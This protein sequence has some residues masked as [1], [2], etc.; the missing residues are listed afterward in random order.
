MPLTLQERIPPSRPYRSGTRPRRALQARAA[1]SAG[2]ARSRA[3]RPGSLD[4]GKYLQAT[5][6][7]NWL[8]SLETPW[9]TYQKRLHL[10]RKLCATVHMIWQDLARELK[11]RPDTDRQRQ[12]WD[13]YEA[14]RKAVETESSPGYDA[15]LEQ[16]AKKRGVPGCKEAYLHILYLESWKRKHRPTG[17]SAQVLSWEKQY[18]QLLHC[19][20]EWIGFKASCCGDRT[21]PVAVPIG[22]N[23]RLCPLCNW[24][25]SQNARRRIKQ[26]FDRI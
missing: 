20:G 15:W 17:L 7:E 1:S 11:A 18:F 24:H 19:E 5:S 3:A 8:K 10:W 6:V 26:V 25:R 9:D 4:T 13:A 23:H 22:C 21:R 2:A 14:E 16:Y 12:W